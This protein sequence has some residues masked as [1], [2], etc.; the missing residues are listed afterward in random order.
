M[1]KENMKLTPTRFTGAA[2]KF[3]VGKN[4]IPD[5]RL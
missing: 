2:V 4:E 3:S 5:V 1:H